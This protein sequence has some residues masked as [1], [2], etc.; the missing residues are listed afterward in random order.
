MK[1]LVN[2][3]IRFTYSAHSLAFPSPNIHDP[4]IFMGYT[5][6]E[7]DDDLNASLDY[8]YLSVKLKDVTPDLFALKLFRV[9]TEW[10]RIADR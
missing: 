8:L 1:N 4:V 6:V 9:K 10:R 3:Y 7:E 5:G 2:T